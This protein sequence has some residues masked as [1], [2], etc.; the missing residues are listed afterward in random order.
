MNTR[1][2]EDADESSRKRMGLF[3]SPRQTKEEEVKTK[4]VN[5]PTPSIFRYILRHGHH[6]NTVNQQS[7]VTSRRQTP[8]SPH[9]VCYRINNR[10]Q[11]PT[12]SKTNNIKEKHKTNQVKQS[13]KRAPTTTSKPTG[14]KQVDIHNTSSSQSNIFLLQ[15]FFYNS[16]FLIF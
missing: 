7:T 9:W 4:D 5:A 3:K 10:S 14:P 2:G 16:N 13:K 6:E 8:T 11:T 12:T 15:Y 1:S